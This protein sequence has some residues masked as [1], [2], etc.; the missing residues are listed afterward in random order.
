M[1]FQ[2]FFLNKY[3]HRMLIFHWISKKNISSNI[4]S[5]SKLLQKYVNIQ[6][7]LSI[8]KGNFWVFFSRFSFAAIR[9]FSWIGC[10]VACSHFW[11]ILCAGRLLAKQSLHFIPIQF[12][13]WTILMWI[14][15]QSPNIRFAHQFIRW[16]FIPVDGFHFGFRYGRLLLRQ[17]FAEINNFRSFWPLCLYLGEQIER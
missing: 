13:H 5:R 15:H 4:N 9:P 12:G 17:Q 11:W 10:R 16:D 14:C 3:F 7:S 6:A 1:N 2:N 8:E